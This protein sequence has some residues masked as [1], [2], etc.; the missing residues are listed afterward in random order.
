MKNQSR[1]PW[2]HPV[3]RHIKQALSLPATLALLL[4]CLI[5]LAAL[6]PETASAETA[7]PRIGYDD[8]ATPRALREKRVEALTT[9]DL[10]RHD[11]LKML[12]QFGNEPFYLMLWKGFPSGGTDGGTEE[13]LVSILNKA[14]GMLPE[15]TLDELIL[16]KAAAKPNHYTLEDAYY[17]LRIPLWIIALLLL[18]CLSLVIALLYNRQKSLLRMAAKNIELA[19]AV[20]QAQLASRAK[21]DFLA[22]ISHEIRTPLNAIISMT[23]LARE[24]VDNREATLQTL[25]KVNLSSRMLLSIILDV[26]NMASIESGKPAFSRVPFDFKQMLSSL[27]A[28]YQEQCRQKGIRFETR[29]LTPIHECLI[30][31]QLRVNQIL[32][33]LLSNAVRFTQQGS[34]CLMV[35]QQPSVQEKT[36]VRFIVKDTGCGLTPERQNGLFQPVGQENVAAADECGENGLSLATVKDLVTFMGGFIAV[37]SEKGKGSAFTVEIPFGC[38]GE[39]NMERSGDI[40]DLRVL[41]IDDEPDAREYASRALACIGTRYYCAASE[42]EALEELARAAREEDAYDVCIMDWKTPPMD[43]IAIARHIRES[44]DKNIVLIVASARTGP[45][46]EKRAAEAGADMCVSKPLFQSSLFDLLISLYGGRPSPETIPPLAHDFTGRRVLLVENNEASRTAGAG[47]LS[48]ARTTVEVATSGKEALDMYLAAPG[49]YYD[50]ILMDIQLP[51]MNGYEATRA[52]RSSGHN[53][54]ETIAIIAMTAN[55]ST[56]DIAAAMDSGMNGHV[57]KPIDVTTLLCT[58]ERHFLAKA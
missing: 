29:L 36:F 47:L 38:C 57:A 32:V 34:V 41:V 53:D 46:A 18:T 56:E 37:E 11:D 22:R 4:L 48:T 27:A 55:A 58:L 51:V 31:D 43:G 17:K 33:S 50:A 24:H 9:E 19:K 16:E 42:K 2:A 49:G 10:V 28:T 3:S 20:E 52:I 7:G 15:A 40:R 13:W 12:A 23:S 45:E 21:G 14:I 6:P 54:A 26:L 25:D 1:T 35:E 8:A 39:K 5:P 30:G 44:Y